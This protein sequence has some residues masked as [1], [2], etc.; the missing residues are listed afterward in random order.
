VATGNNITTV[1]L[2]DCGLQ[3]HLNMYCVC[4]LTNKILKE[5]LPKATK[6]GLQGQAKPVWSKIVI[7]KIVYHV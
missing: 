6:T 7:G 3:M 4:V 5:T 1:I 2:N